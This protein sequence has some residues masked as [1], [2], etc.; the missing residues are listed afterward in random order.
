M[1]GRDLQGDEMMTR[2]ILMAAAALVFAAGTASA[3]Q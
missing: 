2:H 1:A 3:Q